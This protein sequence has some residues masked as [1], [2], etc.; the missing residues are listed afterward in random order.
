[1]ENKT[2]VDIISLLNENKDDYMTSEQI[3]YT[4]SISKR[5][6]L[7][8]LNKIKD[9]AADHGFKIITKQGYGC[10]LIIKDDE[11]FS[12]WYT[13]LFEKENISDVQK[14]RKV[15][16]NKLISSSNYVNI[17][18]LADELYIS[19]SSARKDIKHLQPLIKKYN[20]T[21]KHS[22]SRGYIIVGEEKD[23]RNAIAK[24]CSDYLEYMNGEENREHHTKILDMLTAS[25][26]KNL[27]SNNISISSNSVN[28]LAIHILIAINRIETNNAI[29]VGSLQANDRKTKEYLTAEKINEDIEKIF[30]LSLSKDEV[31][32][33][34]QH[35]KRNNAALD[36]NL[37]I[38]LEDPEVITFYNL[39]LRAIY[40]H[41]DIDFFNDDNLRLN[42]MNHISLFLYRLNHDDQIKKSNLSSIKDAFPYANELA[43]IG[44]RAIEEKY[45]KSIS[46]E[47]KLYFAIHLALSLETNKDLKKYNLAV[48]LDDS[49][50]IFKLISYKI[51]QILKERI[52]II[53]L[54]S[55]DDVNEEALDQFDI[56]I[57]AT[58]KKLWFEKPTISTGEF[59]SDNDITLIK[60]IMDKLDEQNDLDEFMSKDLYFVLDCGTKEELLECVIEKIAD[61]LCF[62]SNEFYQSVIERERYSSTAYSKRI[63][64]PHP[65]DSA[66]FPNFIS[67][68]R[69]NK[70]ILWDDKYVQLVFL[71]SLN[72]SQKTIQ[73]FFKELSKIILSNDK[74]FQLQKTNS[75]EEF[76]EV[77]YK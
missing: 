66:K 54:F 15:I 10:K 41:S 34:S 27:T 20:L 17:Y 49:A 1:M 38:N 71:F 40:I 30:G 65:L 53:Q 56:I 36:R 57:N 31:Y 52:N 22:H 8:Y 44:L 2:Y 67:I 50:T 5:T 73:I 32:Y 26:E 33:F 3:A 14:R 43:V 68:C 61:K 60:L 7:T 35:I 24:E 45:Q 46:E 39:F 47:E 16:F 70:P 37:V 76:I 18:D 11:I 23:I 75:Y 25:I 51:N 48:I 59:I 4:L 69:L 62:N 42:L 63:A 29:K 19:V 55:F 74:I 28:S 77:F 6:V 64:I 12:E 21:L 72:S 9:D 13:N 58:G